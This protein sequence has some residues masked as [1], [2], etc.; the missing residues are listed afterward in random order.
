MKWT[1]SDQSEWRIWLAFY[2]VH[3]DLDGIWDSSLLNLLS[4]RLQ[5]CVKDEI[6]YVHVSFLRGTTEEILSESPCASSLLTACNSAFFL[7]LVVVRVGWGLQIE[8]G[9]IH[10]MSLLLMKCELPAPCRATPA[11][12]HAAQINGGLPF[13]CF[14]ITSHRWDIQDFLYWEKFHRGE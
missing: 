13:L 6:F 14:L 10:L 4:S 7:L 1:S 3:L 11:S 9:F 8:A 5:K 12:C 2:F